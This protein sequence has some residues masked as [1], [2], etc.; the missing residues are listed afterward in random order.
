VCEGRTS[1]H[2]QLEKI[3]KVVRTVL[4]GCTVEVAIASLDQIGLGL[5]ARQPGIIGSIRERVEHGKDARRRD[6]EGSAALTRSTAGS[7]PVKVAV[8]ALRQLGHGEDT[9]CW[10]EGM[11]GRLDPLRRDLKDRTETCVDARGRPI[12][13]AV[14]ALHQPGVREATVPVRPGEP[15][16]D[17]LDPLRGHLEDG[18][19]CRRIIRDRRRQATKF[20]HAIE[21]AITSLDQRA[22]GAGTV[23]RC[24]VARWVSRSC[25]GVQ[26]R[27][28]ARWCELKDGPFGVRSTAA[29]TVEVAVTA[30]DQAD[31]AYTVGPSCEGVQDRLN[32]RWCDLKTV[33]ALF[34]PP[35]PVVP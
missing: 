1:L 32:A 15:I 8:T 2:N 33:P 11:E 10:G 35:P 27:L 4:I 6:L 19:A 17:R 3:A 21:V 20:G 29:G 5:G 24:A 23:I 9:V 26:D 18:A 28:N 7:C 31:R 14:T 25:E 16:E 34:A 22:D 12:K 30:L 13:V